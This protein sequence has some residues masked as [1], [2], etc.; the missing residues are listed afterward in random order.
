[1]PETEVF[2]GPGGPHRLLLSSSPGL[3]SRPLSP[4]VRVGRSA[5]RD[6]SSPLQ[7]AVRPR[8]RPWRTGPKTRR[9][10]GQRQSFWKRWDDG[11][12][13]LGAACGRASAGAG[14]RRACS[15]PTSDVLV[16]AA[17]APERRGPRVRLRGAGPA[18]A[19]AAG[20]ARLGAPRCCPPAWAAAA[21]PQSGGQGDGG[22][23]S[24][25]SRRGSEAVSLRS[26]KPNTPSPAAFSINAERKTFL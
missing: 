19:A 25:V 24:E 16:P 10:T 22:R 11:L 3:S 4:W 12:T 26:N 1:M 23:S 18:G 17:P 7:V 15:L 13:G 2:F 6:L 5:S 9:T 14:L 20:A 21:G 8:R